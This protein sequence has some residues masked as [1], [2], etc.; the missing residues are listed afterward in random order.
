MHLKTVPPTAVSDQKCSPDSSCRI[1]FRPWGQFSQKPGKLHKVEPT[2]SKRARSELSSCTVLSI[3]NIGSWPHRTMKSR[4]GM[5]AKEHQHALLS[6]P[7]D[8]F[9][10]FEGNFLTIMILKDISWKFNIPERAKR[11]WW[12][13]FTFMRNCDDNGKT[14]LRHLLCRLLVGAPEADTRQPGVHKV[15]S[16]L[17]TASTSS[18][19]SSVCTRCNHH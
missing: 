12:W 2:P 4:A 11:Q 17:S 19:S 5:K 1:K 9:D 16:S 8:C 14:S 15:Q 13:R 10:V 6:F 3:P 18:S 7:E